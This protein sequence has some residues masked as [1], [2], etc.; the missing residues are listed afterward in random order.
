MLADHKWCA[1]LKLVHSSRLCIGTV[2]MV[3]DLPIFSRLV[4]L[5]GIRTVM[6]HRV[7]GNCGWHLIKFKL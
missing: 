1:K 6:R 2:R 4:R 3:W 7:T 5:L